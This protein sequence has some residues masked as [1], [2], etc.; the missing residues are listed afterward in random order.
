MANGTVYARRKPAVVQL[1]AL[2]DLL[3]IMIFI[4]L[5]T[6]G[7]GD[8]ENASAEQSQTAKSRAR[9][10]LLD[11][12]SN[13]GQAAAEEGLGSHLKKLFTANAYYVNSRGTRE[14]RET[15]LWAA[16]A[17]VGLV[18]FRLKLAEGTA[19]IRT[20]VS[21]PLAVRDGEPL[22]DCTRISLTG[23]RIYQN[24]TAP[25]GRLTTIDCERSGSDR[26]QCSESLSQTGQGRGARDWSW[27][28]DLELISVYDP[29]FAE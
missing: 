4:G 18:R 3:F 26:Y 12:V 25:F 27:E 24:C 19:I 23:D 22:S 11:E 29:Q 9:K 17:D 20:D 8:A 7:Q 15:A 21:E 1:T 10:Q 13:A 6:P 16:D 5:L 2:L 14:Y 28:Y